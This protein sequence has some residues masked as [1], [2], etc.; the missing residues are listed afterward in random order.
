MLQ[1]YLQEINN[2]DMFLLTQ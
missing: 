2:D 1:V